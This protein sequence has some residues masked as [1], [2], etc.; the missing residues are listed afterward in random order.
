MFFCGRWVEN[1]MKGIETFHLPRYNEIT[2]VGLY[3]EQTAQY[4]N[5]YL[6]PLGCMEI[7]PSMI[8]NYIKQGLIAKP[9]KKQYDADQIAYL[10][11][12]AIAKNVLSLENI[13]K[14]FALQKKTYTNQAAYD[15]FC[16]ELENMLYYIF[17]LKE[18]VDKIG[19]TN[20]KQKEMLRSMIIS[21][22]N[23]IYLSHCF[24]AMETGDGT[25]GTRE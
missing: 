18:S 8:S 2:K 12:I 5:G 13:A 14:L 6:Q 22:A 10:I 21:V 3:L 7:T 19:T 24:D 15:Y 23:I 16:S 25:T 1:T 20:T 9:V 11:F 4:I 17:G